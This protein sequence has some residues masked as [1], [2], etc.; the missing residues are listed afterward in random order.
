MIGGDGYGNAY[1]LDGEGRIYS[2]GNGNLT[3]TIYNAASQVTQINFGSGDSDTFTYDPAGRMNKYQYNVGSQSVVGTPNWNANGTLGSL[4][5]TDPFNSADAQS[6]NYSHD[7]LIRVAG[8]NCTSTPAWAQTFTYDAFGNINKSGNSSFNASY[9]ASTN[10]MT[11]IASST[12]TY[13]SDGNVTNDFLHTYS[14]DAYGKPVTIDGAG[15]TYD[16]LGR[17]VEQNKNGTYTQV[18]YAPSGFKMQLITGGINGSYS[19][20][21]PLPGG[22]MAVWFGGVPH[23][24]H[25]DW[26]GSSRLFSTPSQ[27]VLGDV[28]YAPFGETYAASGSPDLSFTGMNQDT[29]SNLYDFP[30]REYGIQ[31]RWPS[32]DPAGLLA[33]DPSDPQSWN[34]Y[35]YVDNDPLGFIDPTGLFIFVPPPPLPDPFYFGNDPFFDGN[36]APNGGLCIKIHEHLLGYTLSQ[37]QEACGVSPPT[38]PQTPG[39]KQ[40]TNVPQSPPAVSATANLNLVNQSTQGMWPD[41]KLAFFIEVFQTGG[42]FD[43]KTNYS[44]SGWGPGNGQQFVDYGNW[45]FGYTC[46]ANYGSYFCQSAAGVARMYRA[47]KQGSNPFGDGIP[48]L[49]PPFGDQKR[50]NQQIQNGA[51][52]QASG[53]AQ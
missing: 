18:E 12:P 45:N 5:I 10:R 11:Q 13:D 32:P 34:R 15:I 29:S 31:G 46:G 30:A 35:A 19:S 40:C 50:D 21:V 33:V 1:S 51:K 36:G 24:G 6:C 16:A 52:A 28:A 20:F 39:P 37:A 4:T 26:L 42:A 23:Y 3:K 17:M 47:V 14:W 2:T 41:T 38:P 27:T 48:F 25:S 7:D 9:S 8:V 44:G 22:E 43:Y 49:R 53:C